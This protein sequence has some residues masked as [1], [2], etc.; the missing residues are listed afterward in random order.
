MIIYKITN[1]LNNKIYIGQTIRKISHR[2]HEYKSDSASK[3]S[4]NTR[5]FNAIKKYGF[6]NFTFET[7]DRASTIEELNQ[8]EIYWIKFYDSTNKR[9][10]YNIMEG[11]KNSNLS[12]E[13]KLKMS[14][15]RKGRSQTKDWID[16][17]ISKAGSADAKKYGKPKTE[18]EKE[19]LSKNS[20]K[21]WQN[22]TRDDSTKQK[23]SQSKKG[24]LPSNCKFVFKILKDFNIIIDT[25]RSTKEAARM[26]PNFTQSMISRICNHKTESKENFTFSFT[27]HG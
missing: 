9:V 21:Y 23:I 10:G 18:K 24:Q 8:K 25:Y 20:A 1:R 13:T 27:Y 3:N 26:N 19:I 4:P 12:D 2:I 22:K 5:I 16:R 15:V 11:G 14:I 6:E 7:I 17:R